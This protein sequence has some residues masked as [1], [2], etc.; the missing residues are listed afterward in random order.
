MIVPSDEEYKRRCNEREKEEGK[1]VPESA[2]NEM[3]GRT[4]LRG[5]WHRAQRVLP[6]V[7]S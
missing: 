1:D 2:V 4:M 6:P 7:L 3:K 5:G